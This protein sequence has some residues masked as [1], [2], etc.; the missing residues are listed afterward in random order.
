MARKRLRRLIKLLLCPK[1]SREVEQIIWCRV[2]SRWDVKQSFRCNAVGTARKLARRIGVGLEPSALSLKHWRD[3]RRGDCK[4]VDETSPRINST[5]FKLETGI[6]LLCPTSNI[7][8]LRSNRNFHQPTYRY[9]SEVDECIGD[10]ASSEMKA[11]RL[12]TIVLPRPIVLQSSDPSRI[13]RI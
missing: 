2:P 12:V 8:S 4:S 6:G 5:G 9:R 13:A 7:P 3:D 1:Q 11:E 10:Y